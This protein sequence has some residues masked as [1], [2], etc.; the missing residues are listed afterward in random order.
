LLEGG[1]SGA[2]EL[3]PSKLPTSIWKYKPKD[4]KDHHE[5]RRKLKNLHRIFQNKRDLPQNQ[6]SA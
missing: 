3:T 5:V 2:V 6:P 1:R 4:S